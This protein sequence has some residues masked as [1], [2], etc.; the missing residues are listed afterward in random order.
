MTD[1]TNFYLTVEETIN[2]SEEWL[3]EAYQ[4]DGALLA[5]TAWRNPN[6]ML[7]DHLDDFEELVEIGLDEACEGCM[8]YC[9]EDISCEEMK[10]KLKELGFIVK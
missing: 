9:A 1:K 2:S 4:E 10:I 5:I 6:E 3:R 7:D 8:L